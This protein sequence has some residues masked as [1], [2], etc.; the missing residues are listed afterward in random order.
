MSGGFYSGTDQGV[1]GSGHRWRVA[2]NNEETGSTQEKQQGFAS[3]L[4]RENVW[5]GCQH[6]YFAHPYQELKGKKVTTSDTASS[7]SNPLSHHKK[8]KCS[9]VGSIHGELQQHF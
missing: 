1:V 9:M 7:F 4:T 2:F 5:M 3:R 8:I 6:K